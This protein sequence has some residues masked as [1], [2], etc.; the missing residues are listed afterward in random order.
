MLVVCLWSFAM[1]LAAFLW[2]D[3][4]AVICVLHFAVI[5][6]G[7]LLYLQVFL[8]LLFLW[9]SRQ[10]LAACTVFLV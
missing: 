10:F 1:N 3:S 5:H 4:N 8:L 7:E 9:L 2:M 6:R